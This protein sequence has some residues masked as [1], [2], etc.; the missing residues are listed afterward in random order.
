MRAEIAR[1]QDCSVTAMRLMGLRA[2]VAELARLRTSLGDS[3]PIGTAD[4][5]KPRFARG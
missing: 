2:E 1:D 5:R 4:I 3:A